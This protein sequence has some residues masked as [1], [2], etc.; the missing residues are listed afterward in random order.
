MIF[1]PLVMTP[2][3][4]RGAS[5]EAKETWLRFA[6]E[7]TESRSDSL[8]KDP[9]QVGFTPVLPWFGKAIGIST[10]TGFYNKAWGRRDNGAPRE[11][12][13]C[14]LNPNG[15]PQFAATIP[16]ER[17]MSELWN[18]IGVLDIPLSST[19]GAPQGGDPR[20][21]CRT[22]TGLNRRTL[23]VDSSMSR[24]QWTC[25]LARNVGRDV[26]GRRTYRDM[27]RQPS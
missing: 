23:A 27:R 10:P 4:H 24:P 5:C 20:L 16:D 3:P 6:L 2:P 22:R 9:A 13:P 11:S 15:V 1:L 8:Q 14:D 17:M 19:W 18:P 25:A 12:L 7:I 21:C 26:P